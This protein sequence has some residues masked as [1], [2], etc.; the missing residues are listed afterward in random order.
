MDWIT[1][2]IAVGSI[3]DAM[4]PGALK[5]SGVTAILSLISFPTFLPGDGFEWHG[6]SLAEGPGNQPGDVE[7]AVHLLDRLQRDN[8]VLVHCS[9]GRNRAPFV[10]ACYLAWK[11]GVS[12]E[13]A[14]QEVHRRHTGMAIEQELLALFPQLRLDGCETGA[15][16]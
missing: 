8:R 3:D 16:P 15:S 4:R 13:E 14:I 2:R 10:V 11:R 9:E 7:R 6:L 5:S 12:L 1:D